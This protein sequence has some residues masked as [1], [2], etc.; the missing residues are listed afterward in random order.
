M[1]FEMSLNDRE[2]FKKEFENDFVLNEFKLEKIFER[3]FWKNF[4]REFEK[5]FWERDFKKVEKEFKKE[6]V[7]KY[8]F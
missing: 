1:G 7:L 4:E 2:G 3:E 8:V 6:C 5:E